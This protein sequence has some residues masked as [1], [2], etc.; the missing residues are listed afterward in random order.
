MSGIHSCDPALCSI[1]G[2]TS[3]RSIAY[4]LCLALVK[5]CLFTRAVRLEW[6]TIIITCDP[7]SKCLCFL[8]PHVAARPSLSVI[9]YFFSAF[10]NSLDENSIG[11]STPSSSY[12]AITQPIP[13][14]LQSV[15]HKNGL[16]SNLGLISM[17]AEAIIAFSPQNAFSCSS[18]HLIFC[19]LCVHS[20]C[21][22]LIGLTTLA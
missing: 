11:L 8:T 15:R 17:G 4:R 12:C 14:L 9:A 2:Q 7:A 1:S 16:P 3:H 18:P 10:D 6:S 21:T 19:F 13:S 20:C 22:C 5:Y